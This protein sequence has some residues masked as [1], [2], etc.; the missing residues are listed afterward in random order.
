MEKT[1]T[2]CLTLH[3]EKFRRNIIGINQVI[4]TPYGEK[5]LVY[6]DWTASGRLYKPIEEKITNTFGPFLANTHTETTF[7]GQF[8]THA[9]HEA[10]KIIKN[11][12]KATND[13]IIIQ[14][15]YGMTGAIQKLQRILGLKVHEKYRHSIRQSL[16]RIPLVFVSSLEHHSN[17]IS[18]LETIADVK[19]I[20]F[21]DNGIPDLNAYENLLRA[22]T[23]RPIYLSISACSNVTGIQ[24]P[25]ADFIR[26]T[27]QYGGKAFVDYAC[28]A[29]Y[30]DM[31]LSV[32]ESFRPDAIVFSP[33]KFLGGPG[34][35]GILIM[36]KDLYQ[37]A[38]PDEP[39][40]GTVIWTDPWDGAVYLKD[41][42]ARE[43]GG[44]P[45]FLLAI[46]TALAVKLKE[47]MDTKK[48]R[49]REHILITKFIDGITAIDGIKLLED[50]HKNRLGVFSIISD[51]IP[52][53]LMVRLLNDLFG[54]QARGGC[55]CAGTYGHYLFHIDREKS[56]KLKTEILHN[57]PEVKPGWTRIS[58]HPTTTEAEIDSVLEALEYI[59]K[60]GLHIAQTDYRLVKGEFYHNNYRNSFHEDKFNL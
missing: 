11:H 10:L 13:F 23:N 28:S 45:G 54:I 50:R 38:I 37:N 39:G 22:Y 56:R 40:G 33:H 2:D 59:Q 41:I 16:D 14:A 57:H 9:Y 26:L 47:Q 27:K 36:H 4:P 51:K 20:P 15:G 29:P 6:T 42:E 24:P 5:K 18:W 58:I 35:G 53:T 3:F 49:Q 7:T 43:T 60:H 8:I 46:K 48:I 19:L 21:D 32:N 31:D 25:V 55:S 1:E 44:T 52:Y 12:V 17:H 34:T 30:V